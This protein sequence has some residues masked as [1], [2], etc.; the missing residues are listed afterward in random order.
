M[1]VSFSWNCT[2]WVPPGGERRTQEDPGGG[3]K[4]QEDPGDSREPREEPGGKEGM[5]EG[6]EDQKR[7]CQFN[8]KLENALFQHERNPNTISAG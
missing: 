4:S 5:T 6:Q 1:I 7:Y 2:G 8:K 3:R